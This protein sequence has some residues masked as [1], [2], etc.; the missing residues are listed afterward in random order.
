MAQETSTNGHTP[1]RWF[2]APSALLEIALF[3]LVLLVVDE[4]MLAGHRFWEISPHPIWL[5]V[6]VTAVQYG[7]NA[8]LLA[9]VAGSAVLLSGDLPTQAFDQNEFEYL[10]MLAK[11]PT[12]WLMM[13]V[14]AGELAMRHRREKDDA[15]ERAE[16]ESRR[17]EE[18]SE[19]YA[20][21]RGA[22]DRLEEHIASEVN[23]TAAVLSLSA[24]IDDRAPGLVLQGGLDA[25]RRLLR[26]DKASIAF[27]HD[28]E[29]QV[30]VQEG[31]DPVERYA[32]W[33]GPDS[34]LFQAVVGEQR[35]VVLNDP[36]DEQILDG[37]GV[38]AIPM[39]DARTGRVIG[40]LKIEEIEFA[41][42]SFAAIELAV[43]LADWI[44][45]TWSQAQRHA[46]NRRHAM[47]ADTLPLYSRSFLNKQR[48]V[49]T[50]IA[51]RRGFPVAELRIRR[52]GNPH[53]LSDISLAEAVAKAA[54]RILRE[55]DLAFAEA[56]RNNSF[57]I[58][59]PLA[60]AADAAI[61]RDRLIQEIKTGLQRGDPTKDV[62]FDVLDLVPAPAS[63]QGQEAR[64][65]RH[66]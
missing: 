33:F 43:A 35:R 11:L 7:T 62:V 45:T 23:S 31:W 3:M 46:R 2:L 20:T 47:L 17:A 42:L 30:A 57:V 53:D 18:L 40:M 16:K 19:A 27:L 64:N 10:F 51:K 5:I 58:L 26:P 54:A 29:L 48:A 22:V 21:A 28:G 6:I 56:D 65:K 60:G 9:A 8:A 24:E 41:D 34:R 12:L 37:Q 63:A 15:Q 32:H 36:G 13:A 59:L 66:A 4:W 49:L 14:L 44:A 52:R 1:R 61:V 39:R 38:L 50:A 55:T 25:L